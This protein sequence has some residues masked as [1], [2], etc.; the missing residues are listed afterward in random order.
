MTLR[1][2]AP[3]L[4]SKQYEK[5]FAE[6]SPKMTPRQAAIESERCLYCFDAPCIQACPTRIDVPAFIQKIASGNLRGSARVILEANILGHSCGRVCPTEVLCEGACVMHEKGEEPIEIGRLQR[7]A[8]DHVLDNHIQLFHAGPSNGKRIACIGSGPASLAC[9][10]SMAQLGYSMTIFDR[11]EIPGG[12]DTYGIAAYKLRASDA[13]REVEMVRDLGIEFRQNTEIGRDISFAQLERDFEAI[14]IGVGLGE[15]WE[16][17]I[18]G[19]NLAGVCGAMEFIEGTKIGAFSEAEVGRR[20]AC[21]GA[22]N[23]A[24]DVVTAAKRLGAEVVHLIYRRGEQEMPAFAYE[25]ELAK[26]DGVTFHW[27]TQPVRILGDGDRVVA[28]ECVRTRT[29]KRGDGGKSRI[30]VVPGS[31]F[32]LE[33][34]MVIRAIGQKPVTDKFREVAGIEV[35]GNGAIAT[36]SHHQTGHA[37]YFAGGDCVN[38]GKEVVDAVA[39]GMA[40]ARGIDEWLGAP[41]GKR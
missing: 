37:K 38:G 5:N 40:A 18:P 15:T 41:R 9:A 26:L 33:V 31:E 24:I 19:A 34:D 2:T 13:L 10:A 11:N 36:N 25:Y 6:I 8:V 23:T 30:A 14:F 28:I 17:D 7:Y 27:F 29:E 21:V 1:E 22:G 20:V 35:R 4:T 39:E 12:L 16:L 32:T 3:K